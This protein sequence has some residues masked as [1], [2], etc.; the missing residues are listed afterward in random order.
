M[1]TPPDVKKKLQAL[2]E[3]PA[4]HLA[5]ISVL[6]GKGLIDEEDLLEY[7]DKALRVRDLLVEAMEVTGMIMAFA[8]MP[9]V[10]AAQGIDLKAEAEKAKEVLGQISEL[11]LPTFYIKEMQMSVDSILEKL[12][13]QPD[14]AATGLPMVDAYLDELFEVQS[15]EL[16]APVNRDLAGRLIGQ[17]LVAGGSQEQLD[18]EQGGVRALLEDFCEWSRRGGNGQ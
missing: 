1:E 3:L 13:D 8:P 18:K 11:V 15:R 9:Q 7:D 4:E 12:G 14:G 10:A 5:L 17:F 16:P 6:A 2:A